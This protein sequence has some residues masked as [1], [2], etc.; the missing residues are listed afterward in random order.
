MHPALKVMSG[1]IVISEWIE[2][3]HIH[4][5]VLGDKPLELE[6]SVHSRA[7]IDLCFRK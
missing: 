3:V 4:G 7:N 6:Q 2:T 1:A 5:R